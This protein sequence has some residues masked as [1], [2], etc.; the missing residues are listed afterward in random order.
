M[1]CYPY[2]GDKDDGQDVHFLPSRKTSNH[3]KVSSINKISDA[4]RKNTP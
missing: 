4:L 3:K 2:N 1:K